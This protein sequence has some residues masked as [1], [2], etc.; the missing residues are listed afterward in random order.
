MAADLQGRAIGDECDHGNKG[1]F[2]P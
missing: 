2:S 1:G